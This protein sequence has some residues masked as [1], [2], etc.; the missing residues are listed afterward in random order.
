MTPGGKSY[1][2]NL[3][4]ASSAL[5]LII[6]RF[7]HNEIKRKPSNVSAATWEVVLNSLIR[8]THSLLLKKNYLTTKTG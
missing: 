4:S 2:N 3:T 7:M 5:S 8:A 6:Y 1:Q